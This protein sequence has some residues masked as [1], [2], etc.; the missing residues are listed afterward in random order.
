LALVKT[1]RPRLVWIGNVAQAS[2]LD[3]LKRLAKT[4]GIDFEPLTRIEDKNLVELLNR[5][6]LMVYTP[7]LEPFGLAPLEAN[8]CGTP[9]VAVA[10][11]G[12]RETIVHGMNGLLAENSP[13]SLAEAID[14]ILC[15]QAYAHQLGQNG[16]RTV[17]ENWS[18]PSAIDRLEKRFT[19]TLRGA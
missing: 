1:P 3:E 14:K 5:A 13:Q 19:E 7:R 8:A 6:R 2:Y 4:I 10:E 9:V 18:L 17:R 16:Y 15:D 12:V 11:G